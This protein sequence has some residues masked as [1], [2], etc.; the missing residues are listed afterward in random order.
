[1]VH[2]YHSHFHFQVDDKYVRTH[3]AYS[4]INKGHRRTQQQ[5]QIQQQLL[6]QKYYQ[7]QYYNQHQQEFHVPYLI[8]RYDKS[9][10][11]SG[12]RPGE[13]KRNLGEKIKNERIRK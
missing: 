5:Q 6:Q 9:L 11:R 7:Q 3:H 10:R 8:D 2:I 13:F 12:G 4:M 1:M